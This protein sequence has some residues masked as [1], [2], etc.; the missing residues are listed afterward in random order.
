MSRNEAAGNIGC[1]CRIELH[2]LPTLL[3]RYTLGVLMRL[4]VGFQ[5]TMKQW[6]VS[7]V[8][9]T[10]SAAASPQATVASIEGIVRRAADDEPIAGVKVVLTRTTAAGGA[11]SGLSTET[12]VFTD[13]DGRFAIKNVA[14]GSYRLLASRNGYMNQAFGQRGRSG[15]GTEFSLTPGQ[16]ISGMTIR[17]T[18]QGSINGRIR[19]DSGEPVEGV[20]VQLQ[21]YVYTPDARRILDTVRSGTTNDRG[22]YRLYWFDPGRYYLL[23]SGKGNIQ[24]SSF[25]VG[26]VA[27]SPTYYGGVVNPAEAIAIDVHSGDDLAA[28]DVAL[29]QQQHRAYRISGTIIDSTLGRPP[30]FAQV[31]LIRLLSNG[32]FQGDQQPSYFNASKGTFEIGDL[33]PGTYWVSTQVLD[34]S[35]G[36]A[37]GRTTGPTG[38]I[39]AVVDVSNRDLVRSAQLKVIVA[40]SDV[41]NLV[42]NATTGFSISGHLTIDGQSISAAAAGQGIRIEL[43]GHPASLSPPQAPVVNTDGTF[44][45]RNI[46]TG[47]YQ[48]RVRGLQAPYYI[49][50]VQLGADDILG[51]TITIRGPLTSTLEVVVSL[52]P[53][54]IEGTVVDAQ[55]KAVS[56]IEVVLIP[57]RQRD[58]LD[59]YSTAATDSNGKFAMRSVAPG[60]YWIFSWEELDAYSYFDPYVLR[61]FLPQGK[62][63]HISELSKETVEVRMIPATQ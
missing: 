5:Q 48:V 15:R 62:A 30:Q 21:R 40:G 32:E 37:S 10:A 46:G 36:G 2:I 25:K 19:S 53:G 56:G 24:S 7:L 20:T 38:G 17:L 44:L 9:L 39:G 41:D 47:E 8:L 23:V 6:I 4:R 34:R 50:S 31:G 43:M 28:I 26:D 27:Y 55:S 13:G 58:R 45:L 14:A 33:G 42:L 57:D 60:D 12:S 49:K 59:L 35:P 18:P 61:E 54:T 11:I 3:R 22:E 16:A 51:Q 1:A 63:V 52:N 29:S